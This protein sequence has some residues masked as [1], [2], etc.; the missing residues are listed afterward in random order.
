MLDIQ[1]QDTQDGAA[2][3]EEK[4]GQSFNVPMADQTQPLPPP[5]AM[6]PLE[7]T[8]YKASQDVQSVALLT[9]SVSLDCIKLCNQG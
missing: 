6:S 1:E 2:I 8:C 3:Q 4:L 9:A 7:P 5:H